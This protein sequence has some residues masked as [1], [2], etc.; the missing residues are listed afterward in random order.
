MEEEMATYSIILDWKIPWSVEPAGL[1]SMG[2]QRVGHDS[3]TM[4]A[5]TYLIVLLLDCMVKLYLASEESTKLSSQMAMLFFNRT[6][7]EWE[8]VLLQLLVSNW[9][10]KFFVL[11]WAILICIYWYLVVDSNYLN[12]KWCCTFSQKL[13][14]HQCFFSGE[15]SLRSW[16]RSHFSHVWLFATSWSVACQAPLSMGFCRQ[17]HWS[18]LSCPPLGDLPDPGIKPP[19]VSCFGRR[20]LYH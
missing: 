11:F 10:V 9:Y 7:N 18:G 16:V 13:S 14:C 19:S 12:D 1:Q 6:S 2:S 15:M 20:V 4:W 3:I 8:F 17:E 5:H